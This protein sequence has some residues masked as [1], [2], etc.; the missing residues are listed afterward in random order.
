IQEILSEAFDNQIEIENLSDISRK[1]IL[2]RILEQGKTRKNYHLWSRIAVAASILLC[3]GI[4]LYLYQ[5]NSQKA[6]KIEVAKNNIQQDST[7]AYLT[8]ANGDRIALSDT[9]EGQVAEQSGI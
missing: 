5:P 2:N 1:R 8:L 7:K 3:L 9:K 4:V 6:E